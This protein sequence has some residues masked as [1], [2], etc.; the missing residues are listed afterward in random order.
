MNLNLKYTALLLE[1]ATAQALRF[2]PRLE[3]GLI[4]PIASGQQVG[5]VQV[6][7]GETLLRDI[8]LLAESEV[9]RMTTWDIFLVLMQVLLCGRV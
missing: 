5:S 6:Y 3:E 1:K 9:G 4:A 8:P 7:S 2:V